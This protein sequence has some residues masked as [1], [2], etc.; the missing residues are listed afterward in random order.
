M[1][2]KELVAQVAEVIAPEGFRIRKWTVDNDLE[3]AEQGLVLRLV[4]DTDAGQET[5]PLEK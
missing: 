3:K 4:R 1:N 2:E 5:L